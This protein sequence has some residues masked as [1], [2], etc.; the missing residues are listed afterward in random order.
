MHA[1]RR[2]DVRVDVAE[3]VGHRAAGR[4]ARRVDARRV[5]SLGRDDRLRE[6]RQQVFHRR[7]AAVMPVEVEIQAAS[8]G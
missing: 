4:Q 2:E 3:D 6:R 7:R 1:D 8:K 5:E